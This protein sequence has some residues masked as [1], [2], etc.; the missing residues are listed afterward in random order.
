[1]LRAKDVLIDVCVR[2]VE[3]GFGCMVTRKPE[4]NTIDSNSRRGA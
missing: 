2:F 3:E 1:M 4:T